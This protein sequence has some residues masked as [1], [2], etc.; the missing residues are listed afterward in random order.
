MQMGGAQKGFE[1]WGEEEALECMQEEPNWAAQDKKEKAVA[2]AVGERGRLEQNC[3][4]FH[5]VQ[6]KK[7]YL[8]PSKPS[9]FFSV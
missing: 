7:K 5:W 1:S 4:C 8:L 2:V 9:S 3:V 6:I